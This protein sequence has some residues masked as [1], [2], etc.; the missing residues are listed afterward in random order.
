MGE[1]FAS[2]GPRQHYG[3]PRSA[4]QPEAGG[5]MRNSAS[6]RTRRWLN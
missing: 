1:L 3:T 4:C 6:R 2:F 5:K